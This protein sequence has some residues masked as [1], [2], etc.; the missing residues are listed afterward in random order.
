ME[1]AGEVEAVGKS[2]NRF[3]ILEEGKQAEKEKL[4]LEAKAYIT[5]RLAAIGEMVT[6]VAHEIN[7][8]LTGVLGYS[9]P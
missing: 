3:N 5:S 6:G 1:L 4:Q 9:K 7:N 8:P 2:V